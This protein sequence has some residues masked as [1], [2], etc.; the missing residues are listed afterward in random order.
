MSNHEKCYCVQCNK[1]VVKLDTMHVF[2]TGFYKIHTPLAIC[3][4]CTII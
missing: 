1:I 2:K 3:K 4:Q